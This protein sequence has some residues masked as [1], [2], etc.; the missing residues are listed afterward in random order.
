MKNQTFSHPYHTRVDVPKMAKDKDG[1]AVLLCLFCTPTH[2]LNPS[3]PAS[4]GTRLVLTAEQTVIRAKFNKNLVC[5]KCGKGGGEMVM[6]QNSYIHIHDC[7]PGVMAMREP[8]KFSKFAEIVN[9]MPNQFIKSRIEKITGRAMPVEEVDPKG[10]KTG[11]IWGYFFWKPKK[12]V[13]HAKRTETP[14]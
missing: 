3:A 2:P 10:V 13:S 8:P 1:N 14:A 7:N 4:C 6:F 11:Q 12:E 5:V 9:T